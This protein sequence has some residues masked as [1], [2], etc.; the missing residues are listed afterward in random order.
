M[1]APL[2]AGQRPKLDDSGHDQCPPLEAPLIDLTDEI[3]YNTADLDDGYEARLLTVEQIADGVDLFKRHYSEA[4]SIYPN[5]AEKLI[6]N[7]ALKSTLDGFVGALITTTAKL[8]RAAG[9]HS[10]SDVRRH[11]PP[12]GAFSSPAEQQHHP[13]KD[14]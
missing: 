7:E 6:F 13:L 5:A 10:L 11:P 14:V 3:A 1:P 4:K 8:V 12:R 2:A 9:A